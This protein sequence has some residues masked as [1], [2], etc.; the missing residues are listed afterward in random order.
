[1]LYSYQ[2]DKCGRKVDEFR[3]MDERNYEL[4]CNEPVAGKPGH[5]CNG[6]MQRDLQAE[7]GHMRTGDLPDWTS[8]SS[9]VHPSQVDEA[10]KAYAHLGVTFD[11]KTG[12]AHVPGNNRMRYLR[13]RG[14]VEL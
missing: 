11:R 9:G 5:H 6:I 14:L 8:M 7:Q 1:M 4:P 3:P 2:C 13:E 12:D 10:N